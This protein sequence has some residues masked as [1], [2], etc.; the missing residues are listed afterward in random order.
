MPEICGTCSVHYRRH[1]LKDPFGQDIKASSYF[2]CPCSSAELQVDWPTPEALLE[3]LTDAWTARPAKV[4][5]DAI[6]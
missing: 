1:S 5:Q 4:A 2:P 3:P 6:F